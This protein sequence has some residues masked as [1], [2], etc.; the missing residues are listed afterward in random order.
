MQ[1]WKKDGYKNGR[2][3]VRLFGEDMEIYE[4]Y[5]DYINYI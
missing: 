1:G 5:T 3:Q 4:M 2:I